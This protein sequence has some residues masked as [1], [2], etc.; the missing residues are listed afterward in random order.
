MR[1]KKIDQNLKL[2]P[3]NNN[4]G[5]IG[6]SREQLHIWWLLNIRNIG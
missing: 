5:E 6:S 1:K 4:F 3:I 2:V